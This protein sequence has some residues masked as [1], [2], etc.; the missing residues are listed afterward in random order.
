MKYNVEDVIFPQD[1]K[2]IEVIRKGKPIHE[3]YD[4]F[5]LKHPPMELSRRA[6]IFAPFDAL[7]GFNEAIASKDIQ[8]KEQN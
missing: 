8:C 1:F 5:Y 6:K 3:K 2:Y 7:K 4:S